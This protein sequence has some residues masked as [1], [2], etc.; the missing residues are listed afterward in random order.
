VIA[1]LSAHLLAD[2]SIT[3]VLT[4]L[5]RRSRTGFDTMD[6]V[7]RTLVAFVVQSGVATMYVLGHC[8]CEMKS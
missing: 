1:N 4:Y 5:L 6:G 3:V 7:L 2:L 8:D